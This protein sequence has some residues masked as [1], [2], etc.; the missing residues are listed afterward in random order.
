VVGFFLLWDLRTIKDSPGDSSG[1]VNLSI[2]IPARNEAHNLPALLKSL[3]REKNGHLFE[4]IVADDNSTDHTCEKARSE[5]ATV[6]TVK[7]K[8]ADWTGKNYACWY[9]AQHAMGDTLLFMDA[10]LRVSSGGILK[11][12]HQYRKRKAPIT[13]Q[14]FHVM[15]KNYEWWSLFFNIM[16]VAGIGAF[17]ALGKKI[18]PSGGFGPFLLIDKEYYFSIGGHKRTK[19]SILETLTM[20]KTMVD[21]LACYVGKGI[22]SF[23]MYPHGFKELW[24][25]WTKAFIDGA[26]AT[27]P[28]VLT[29]SIIWLSGLIA[30]PLYSI[31]M[32]LLSEPLLFQ[33]SFIITGIALFQ[34][35]RIGTCIGNFNM[36]VFLVYPLYLVFF[37]VLFFWSFI[38]V[39]VLHRV[40]WKDRVIKR[41]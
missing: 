3:N 39:R 17:T 25:G 28:L 35:F 14:P 8:S 11:V 9:G 21:T 40:T 1:L 6:L 41:S 23:R 31:G 19:D 32:Y 12:I 5:G 29:M 15:E 7:D 4:I 33:Y 36:L 22:V 26:S 37:F 34:L 30:A 20:G 38:S 10:D 24:E 27:T 18:K 2:I 16:I 13:I